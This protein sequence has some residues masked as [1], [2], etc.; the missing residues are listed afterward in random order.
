[1]GMVIIGCGILFIACGVLI[2]IAFL[3]HGKYLTQQKKCTAT[4]VGMVVGVGK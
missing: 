1:M 3:V 4:A 2:L